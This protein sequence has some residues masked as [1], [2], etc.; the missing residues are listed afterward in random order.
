MWADEHTYPKVKLIQRT[1]SCKQSTFSAMVG[2][3]QIQVKK[4]GKHFS[5]L[6]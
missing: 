2:A 3:D 4:L 1:E 6:S 5:L